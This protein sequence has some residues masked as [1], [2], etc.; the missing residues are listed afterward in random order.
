AQDG[1][2]HAVLL[3]PDQFSFDNEC[4]MLNMVGPALAANIQ[5]FT[6]SRL[7]EAVFR[8]Y[9]GI[10]EKRIDDSART[11]LMALAIASCEDGLSLYAN[12]AKSD[13]ITGLILEAID[14]FKSAGI[15]PKDLFTVAEKT[16]GALHQKMEELALIYAAFEAMLLNSY[17]EPGDMLTRLWE[18][19]R[20]K[21][22]FQGKTV[23]IDGFE[24]FNRQK[25]RV[26]S[27]ILMYPVLRQ[28]L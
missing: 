17:I 27:T 8:T 3:V 16:Y 24:G 22:F 19:L 1:G 21:P 23:F 12:A 11:L 4:A 13:R 9:G 6:F 25:M 15:A 5:I 14:E 28:H 18:I 7:A 10:T 20:E 26:L 2:E